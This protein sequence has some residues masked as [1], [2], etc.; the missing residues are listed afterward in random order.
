MN[1]PECDNPY[2]KKTLKR[3]SINC[4]GCNNKYCSE[5]CLN[6]HQQTS[7]CHDE[8]SYEEESFNGPILRKRSN[9]LSKFMKEGIFLKV[10]EINPMFDMENFE[11]VT[12]GKAPQIIGQGIYG[13]I[14][15]AKNKLNS[16]QYA[17]KRIEKE[18]MQE[19]NISSDII[20]N[21]I[22]LHLKLIH[23]HIIRLYSFTETQDSFYLVSIS[24]N[25]DHGLC[26]QQYFKKSY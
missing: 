3:I 22:N 6:Y 25:S 20:Y 17:I 12:I 7:N 14:F 10:L 23:D 9:K 18:R 8:N 26:F 11:M 2:C 16:K 4:L 19:E 1:K 5:K 13:N 21:E 15:L 24:F